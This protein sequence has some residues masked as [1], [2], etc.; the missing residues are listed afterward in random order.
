LYKIYKA[1]HEQSPIKIFENN[2]I[3]KANCLFQDDDI[4]SKLPD[5]VTQIVEFEPAGEP[6]YCYKLALGSSPKAG[7]V[8]AFSCSVFNSAN[9][10]VPSTLIPIIDPEVQGQ[11]IRRDFLIFFSSPIK[12]GK[13]RIVLRDQIA[14]AMKDIQ[15]KGKDWMGITP[16]R[17]TVGPFNCQLILLV[18]NDY[19]WIGMRP[20][21]NSIPGRE[22]QP[23]E[24]EKYLYLQNGLRGLGWQ[25]EAV[26]FGPPFRVEFYL[27]R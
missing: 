5:E 17:A 4:R 14:G 25:G 3:A 18:P 8:P 22:M 16:R 12:A 1:H 2:L 26:G 27:H 24:L 6:V 9:E 20:R 19:P 10:L 23:Q 15:E 7:F 11:S 21:D 13:H